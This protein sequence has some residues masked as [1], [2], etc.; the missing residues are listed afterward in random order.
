MKRMVAVFLTLIAAT[1]FA[2]NVILE[3]NTTYPTKKSKMAIQWAYSGKDVDNANNASIQHLKLDPSTLQTL[4]QTRKNT[5]KVPDGAEYFRIVV[6]SK[7]EDN[8]DLLTNW[9]DIVPS[10]N[11]VLKQDHLVPAVLMVG[12]GC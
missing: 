12:V 9:V 7:E 5:I 2:E 1:G 6:W 8:P 10:K 4:S 3:N 11:Y